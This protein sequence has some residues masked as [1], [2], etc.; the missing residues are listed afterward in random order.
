VNVS[1]VP[2]ANQRV[3]VFWDERVLLHDTGRALH[4]TAPPPWFDPTQPHTEGPERLVAM[5][6]ALRSGPLAEHVVWCA[7]RLAEVSELTR[8]HDP[9]YIESIARQCRADG[10]WVTGTTRLGAGSWEPLM[11]A[12]G[13]V[14][15]ATDAVLT[16]ATPRA[17]ALVRPPGH[18]AQKGQADGYCFFNH[19]ALVADL[20]RRSG[21]DRV[22]VIDWDVHHGNGT[23]DVFYARDDVLTVSLH[24]N[25]GAWGPS[26]PQTGRPD[27]LGTGRG[28]GHNVNVPLPLGAGD[29][30]YVRALDEVVIPIVEAYA[31]DLIVCASGQDASAFDPNGRH[32]VTMQGFRTIGSRMRGLAD[33]MTGGRLVAVQEGG[34]NPSYAAF[35]LLATLEGLENVPVESHTADPLAYVPDQ[36][37][38]VDEAL[39]GVRDTLRHHWPTLG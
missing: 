14:L 34:Y 9:G 21:A 27:E 2:A 8:I 28:E 4:E 32:N 38:G 35:C 17:Y 36:S 15:A 24:M 10:G 11:A 16:E 1:N 29:T 23:Q 33:R 3:H 26:H 7:G 20:A 5:V 37:L 19:A 31:P 13:T 25:H 30:A 39:S 12:A 6:A 18:H 22:A